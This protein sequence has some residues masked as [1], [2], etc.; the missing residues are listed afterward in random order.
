[1]QSKKE[2]NLQKQPQ[3]PVTG[4]GSN[5]STQYD[6]QGSNIEAL[7]SKIETLQNAYNKTAGKSCNRFN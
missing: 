3:G 6:V 4:F 7:K 1:L 5:V 2:Q